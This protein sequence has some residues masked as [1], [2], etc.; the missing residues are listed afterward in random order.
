MKNE[1]IDEALELLA[2]MLGMELRGTVFNKTF[3]GLMRSL[4]DPS[5]VLS[6]TDC[7]ELANAFQTLADNLTE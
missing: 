4:E 5:V 1:N 7:K 3:K 2:D 6:K